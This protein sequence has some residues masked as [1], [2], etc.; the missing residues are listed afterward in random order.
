MKFLGT[1]ITSA[2]G[3]LG[4]IVASHNRGGGYLRARTVPVN[5]N[6]TLQVDIR[7]IMTNLAIAWQ[8]VLTQAER[9]AWTVYADNTAWTNGIGES[10]VLTGINMFIRSNSAIL[11]AGGTRIDAAPT[12]FTLAPMEAALSA[13][14]SVATQDLLVAFD[15]TADWVDQD[16]GLQLIF[17]GIPKNSGVAFFG[18]PYRLAG[19]INGNATTPPTTPATIASPFPFGLN[20]RLWIQSRVAED[21][22]RLS[23]RAQFD[24]LTAA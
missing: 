1:F 19:V 8:T 6:T 2:S 17:V 23:D 7:T 11:Q 20:N 21:D 5:P 15:D 10:I 24:F 16:A 9:D 22:G 12:I 13:T 18:G 14:A 3:S 4:G